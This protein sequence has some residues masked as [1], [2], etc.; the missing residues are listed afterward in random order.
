M[1][2]FTGSC[3][4]RLDGFLGAAKGPPPVQRVIAFRFAQWSGLEKAAVYRNL[5]RCGC[6][7]LDYR[8]VSP[9]H[10]LNKSTLS[11][12]FGGGGLREENF[13]H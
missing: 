13:N 3:T 9:A 2:M 5:K 10:P 12:L 8:C 1:K 6:H 4:G 11:G 7:T